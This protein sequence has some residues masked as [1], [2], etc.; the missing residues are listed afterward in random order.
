MNLT[1][2]GEVNWTGENEEEELEDVS[3]NSAES[4]LNRNGK[5]RKIS[6]VRD[7]GFVVPSEILYMLLYY[8]TL[9]LKIAIYL[10]TP[11]VRRKGSEH[12]AILSILMSFSWLAV[13]SYVLIICLNEMAILFRINSDSFGYT[14][15][16]WAASYP[17]LWSSVVVARNGFGDMAAS[18]ALGSNT[19]SNLIG[20]GIPWLLY[21]LSSGSQQPYNAIQ[22]AGVVLFTT[23]LTIL[24]FLI[25]GMVAL[26]GFKLTY[27]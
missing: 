4:A 16:A 15:G 3:S 8:L 5:T 17:A 19:F 2:V 24:L 1:R 26:A 22:D 25:Y 10:T 27:W 12:R 11:D 14:V 21:T 13:E 18:N 6:S 9:P 20:L 23:I 7:T